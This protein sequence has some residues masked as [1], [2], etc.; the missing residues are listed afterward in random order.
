MSLNA[1]PAEMKPEQRLSVEEFSHEDKGVYQKGGTPTDEREMSR[2]G[3][4]Q[5]LRVCIA[6]HL[7]YRHIADV[8]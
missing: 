8:R 2:M 3:K 4:K 1:M 5:E 6:Y 7:R